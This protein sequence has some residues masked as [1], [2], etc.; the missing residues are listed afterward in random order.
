MLI[1]RKEQ[2]YKLEDE[3]CK[4]KKQQIWEKVKS[5]FPD[6]C[7]DVSDKDGLKITSESVDDAKSI[8]IFNNQDLVLFVGMA[9][10]P[11][12]V[13]DD[14]WISSVLIRILNQHEK[15]A[16][17]RLEFLYKH[18]LYENIGS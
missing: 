10:L 17:E 5:T 1:I 12:K 2:L 4:S 11:K 13:I 18:V 6:L 7:V 14:P 9:F 16:S 8:N 3:Y 15:L